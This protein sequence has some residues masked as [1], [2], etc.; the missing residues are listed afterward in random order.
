QET[1]EA[2]RAVVNEVLPSDPDLEAFLCMPG[3]GRELRARVIRQAFEGRADDFFVDFL[4][5]LN[6]HDRLNLLRHVLHAYE[7]LY[8]QRQNRVRVA[9]HSAAPLPD[10]QRQRLLDQLRGPMRREPVVEFQVDPALLG[11]L[12]IRVGDF[13]YNASTRAQVEAIRD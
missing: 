13:L 12:V 3:G 5:V 1:L 4:L 9:A 8:D 10:D 11:G 2:L 6:D 7:Q